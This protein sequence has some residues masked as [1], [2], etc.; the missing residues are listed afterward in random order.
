MIHKTIAIAM[1]LA[2]ALGILSY[3]TSTVF[4]NP[5]SSNAG[6]GASGGSGGSGGDGGNGGNGG[7]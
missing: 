5:C 4:A 3:G 6:S 1:G 7:Y 2:L